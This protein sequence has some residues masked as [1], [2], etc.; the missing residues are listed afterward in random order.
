MMIDTSKNIEENLKEDLTHRRKGGAF[1]MIA[2]IFKSVKK[3]TFSTGTV[4]EDRPGVLSASDVVGNFTKSKSVFEIYKQT[5]S[6]DTEHN[7]MF[8][9]RKGTGV[10]RNCNYIEL[11]AD[12][13]SKVN[14]SA[15]GK[16]ILTLSKDGIERKY[17]NIALIDILSNNPGT[18]GSDGVAAVINGQG[19]GGVSIG[20][21]S[22]EGVGLFGIII[23]S[24][25]IQITGLP[26]SAPSTPNT[27]YKSG[28][29]I[30]ST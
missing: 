20:Y 27:L 9:G 14:D 16:I 15:N 30:R 8:I 12:A 3:I 6:A 4:I 11:S 10:Y 21:F 26:T 2:R 29:Y 19:D 7:L 17:A 23:D 5:R 1:D 24:N 25:G 13:S 18:T 22:N 28:G